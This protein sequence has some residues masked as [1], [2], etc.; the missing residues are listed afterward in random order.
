VVVRPEIRIDWSDQPR[1]D[2]L[3]ETDQLLLAVDAILKF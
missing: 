3:A 2:A 1:F